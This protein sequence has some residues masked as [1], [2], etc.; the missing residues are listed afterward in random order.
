MNIETFRATAEKEGYVFE[1]PKKLEAGLENAEHAHHF[2]AAVMVL[3]GEITIGVGGENT[4][5]QPGDVCHM[6]SGTEHTEL[7]GPDGVTLLV[8]KRLTRRD[9]VST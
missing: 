8:G 2:D 3:D 1:E 6:A 4:T 5:Y 9:A 7:A